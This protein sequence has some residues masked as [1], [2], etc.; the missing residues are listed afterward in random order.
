MNKSK[1]KEVGRRGKKRRE[2]RKTE[3]I[4]SSNHSLNLPISICCHWKGNKY[5]ISIVVLVNFVY[6][7]MAPQELSMEAMA[8]LL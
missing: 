3:V 8:Y 4:N 5:A 1:K 7:Q 2:E 6:I